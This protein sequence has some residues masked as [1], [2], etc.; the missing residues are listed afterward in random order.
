MQVE[1]KLALAQHVISWQDS[2]NG[3]PGTWTKFKFE[4]TPQEQEGCA[5]LLSEQIKR[6]GMSVLFMNPGG[7]PVIRGHHELNNAFWTK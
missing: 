4:S 6:N 1:Q 7:Q 5:R 2:M 3:A